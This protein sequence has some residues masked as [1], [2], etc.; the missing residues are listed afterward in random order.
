MHLSPQQCEMV[1]YILRRQSHG[2]NIPSDI[3]DHMTG[4]VRTAVSR[5]RAK[6]REINVTLDTVDGYGYR[7]T[8]DNADRLRQA[9]GNVETKD[10]SI[11]AGVGG[12]S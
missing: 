7:L 2:M 11:S 3:L 1:D 8:A 9:I 12:S 6:L 10:G 5:L 4:N